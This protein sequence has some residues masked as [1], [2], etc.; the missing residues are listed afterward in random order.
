MLG[1]GPSNYYYNTPLFSILG[2]TVQFNS[3]NN[4]VDITAQMGLIGLFIYFWIFYEIARIGLKL[5][6][7]LDEG[8]E[9]AYVYAVLGAVAGSLVASMLG[10][11]V[12]PFYYNVGMEGFRGSLIGWM[13]F[14]GLVAIERLQKSRE[15]TPPTGMISTK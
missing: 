6:S 9:K 8:F 4:L 13:F 3:H 5:R 2:W 10:D 14:G 11:W 12:I 15:I 7:T 1:L